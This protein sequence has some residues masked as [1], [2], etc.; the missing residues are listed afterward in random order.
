MNQLNYLIVLVALS[1]TAQGQI[2][3]SSLACEKG[4]NSFTTQLHPILRANCTFCHD[5]GGIGPAHSVADTNVSY[6]SILPFVNFNDLSNS[7]LIKKFQTKHWEAWG[8]AGK[9]TITEEALSENISKW[10]EMGQKECPETGKSLSNPIALPSEL[11]IGEKATLSW[12]LPDFKPAT[13]EME[14]VGQGE[15]GVV[16]SFLL[17]KPRL[18][19]PEKNLAVEGVHLLFNGVEV[20]GA[21][22][23]AFLKANVNAGM[24]APVLSSTYLLL[25]KRRSNLLQIAFD[26]LKESTPQRCHHVDIFKEKVLPIYQKDCFYCHQGDE[27]PVAKKR[28]DMSIDSMESLCDNSLQRVNGKRI[29]QVPLIALPLGRANGHAWAIPFPREIFPSWS[30]WIEMERKDGAKY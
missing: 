6:I 26:E 18:V 22:N 1:L 17:W 28:F 15:E 20:S 8:G 2:K 30:D 23:L 21:N 19:S 29:D 3:R 10:W 24:N 9:V 25:L 5:T 4:M 16:D 7:L 12:S 14:I 13:F 11:K 27:D